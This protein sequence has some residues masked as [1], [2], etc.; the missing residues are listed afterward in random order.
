MQGA[1]AGAKN[2]VTKGHAQGRSLA[3]KDKVRVT[4]SAE[5]DEVRRLQELAGI[6][7]T[8]TAGGTSAGGIAMSNS[9]IG[10]T[11]HPPTVKLRAKLRRKKE[12]KGK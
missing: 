10:D 11:S 8:S 2:I 6:G 9:I 1:S 5:Q 7:E 4:A 3:A 12:K